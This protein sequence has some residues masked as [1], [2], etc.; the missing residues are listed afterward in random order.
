MH[1]DIKSDNIF[2]CENDFVK[3]GDLGQVSNES[4]S[5]S[6]VGTFFYRAPEMKILENIKKKLIYGEC[7]HKSGR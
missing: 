4:K 1:K 3:I 5:K 2:L 7:L 6:F